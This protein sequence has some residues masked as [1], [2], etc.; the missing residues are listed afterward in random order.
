MT[1][2]YHLPLKG[3]AKVRT[4]RTNEGE[5]K[6]KTARGMKSTSKKS[7]GK[8]IESLLLEEKVP[9]LRGG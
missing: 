9:S 5:T 4:L 6:T 3:K 7:E 8:L 1:S 2:I